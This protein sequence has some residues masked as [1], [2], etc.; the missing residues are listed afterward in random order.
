MCFHFGLLSGS[1]QRL[2]GVA[3]FLDSDILL[4]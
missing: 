2:K 4:V 3:V 1:M